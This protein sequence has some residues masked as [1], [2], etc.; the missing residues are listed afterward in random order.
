MYVNYLLEF[1]YLYSK[2]VC[3]FFLFWSSFWCGVLFL[4]HY[5]FVVV[6]IRQGVSVRWFGWSFRALIGRCTLG[7]VM[8]VDS[9]WGWFQIHV[10]CICICVYIYIY[11]ILYYLRFALFEV[12]YIYR[13]DSGVCAYSAIYFIVCVW[14]S[15]SLGVLFVRVGQ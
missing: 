6:F 2:F 12:V 10:V 3:L 15:C 5:A 13:I 1:R 9:S 7:C 14:F 11:I 4:I 8:Y